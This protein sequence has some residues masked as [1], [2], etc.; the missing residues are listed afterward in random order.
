MTSARILMADQQLELSRFVAGFWRLEHWDMPSTALTGYIQQCID[1]GVTTM[2]HAM[3]YR[4]ES[5]FG[6]ALA[7]QPGLRQ[8]I[9]IVT[10]FGIRP[11]GFGALGAQQTNHYDSSS[12]H[13]TASV[14]Q[15]LKDLGTDYIDLLLVHRPDYLMNIDETGATL[16]NLIAAGKVRAIG[17]SN[18][19][20]AQ[21]SALQTA[22]KHTL[23]TNQIEFSPIAMQALDNGT[24]EQCQTLK[25]QPMLWS[26]LAGGNLLRADTEKSKR[27]M[28]A[29]RH[30][31]ETLGAASPEQVIYAW[32]LALPCNPL[33]L[34]GTSQRQ[35]I[36]D[37]LGST[38][39][40]LTREQWYQIWEASN[41]SPVP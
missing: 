34:L 16:D 15:S 23:V 40:R 20:P 21:F 33:I 25:M 12:Q 8:K 32:A 29:V 9:E 31:Q 19:T 39:V 14:N 26:C 27:I 3:V 6:Q 5:L 41:G 7:L 2:D 11:K 17:V 35:R 28:T 37:A 36:S 13:I 1:L 18:F 24:F 10:K 38:E 30:I 22:C 4:S